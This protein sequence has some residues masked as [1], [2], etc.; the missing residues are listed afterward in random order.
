[1][2]ATSPHLS[3]QTIGPAYL[4]DLDRA[5]RRRAGAFYTPAGLAAGLVRLALGD[6]PA[7]VRVCD[8]AVGAGA[9]LLAAAD[10][11]AAAGLGRRRIVEELLWGVDLDPGAVDVCRRALVAWAAE[12][13]EV[14]EPRHVVVGDGL[15]GLES[16]PDAPAAG[17]DAVVGNPPFQSQLG[18]ATARDAVRAANLRT[19]FGEILTPYVDTAALFLVAAT[20]AVAPGGRVVLVLPE[21]VLSARD[22][23]P[24][25]AAALSSCHMA[26]FWW[27][28]AHLFDA[29]V[30]VCAPVLERGG[31]PS[32]VVS[33]WKGA[34]VEPAAPATLDADEAPRG[35][36]WGSLLAPE[37]GPAGP[38]LEG[39]GVLGDLARATAGFRDQFYGIAA[40]VREAATRVAAPAGDRRARLVTSGLVDP[41]H[42]R[43]GAAPSRFAGRRWDAPEVDLASL[44]AA[45]P[46]LARWG[47]ERLVPKV[48]LATQTRVLE[49]V[50]DVDGSWWP[51][52]PTIAVVPTGSAGPDDLWAIAAV[53]AAPP[54]SAWAL[55]R[56]RG[57]ALGRDAVKLAAT[58][59]LDLPLPGD[60]TG[61]ARGAAAARDA[62]HAATGG[63]AAR[64]RRALVELGRAMTEAY[65]ATPAIFEWWRDR[66]P[67]WR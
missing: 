9:F 32:R 65:D 62:Q 7:G 43:W 60:R 63:D 49:P 4:A 10:L 40:H 25:R 22:A 59:V 57:T 28:G 54:V 39:A 16:W 48:L 42:L 61:W 45:D 14:A 26:G 31:H 27:A 35:G 47:H 1:M 44:E 67:P 30:D 52:V 17:F 46:R 56:H 12:G 38:R 11:L 20:R 18:R 51:S 66:L 29:L 37:D 23:G 41:L 13:G 50:V 2:G 53:L 24:A 64:W 15:A 3:P 34:E 55:D 6:A 21:S 19:R 58:Q 8:P 36:S 33:R 5:E